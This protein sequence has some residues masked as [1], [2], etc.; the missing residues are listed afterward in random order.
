MALQIGIVGCG[1]ISK[2]HFPGFEAAGA[3]IR[4]V[5]D[6]DEAVAAPWKDRY[7]ATYTDDYTEVTS[8]PEI[9]VV[10]ITAISNVHR[11]VALSAFEHGKSV[12]CEKTLAISAEDAAEIVEA[13]RDAGVKLFTSYMK[14]F[15]PAVEDAKRLLSEGALGT[16][17]STSIRAF[18]CWGDLW[19]KAPKEGIFS[20]SHDGVSGVVR[21][22]GGGILVCGGSHILDLVCH[23]LGRPEKLL[24]SMHVPRGADF[25]VQA[26]AFLFTP[27]GIAHFEALAHPLDRIG[28]L[29]DGW[30]ERIEIVGTK[31]R[32]EVLSSSWNEVDAKGS[33]LNYY[34]NATRTETEHRYGPVSP[35]TRAIEAFCNA[36]ATGDT[37]IQSEVTGY[38]VDE[39]ISCVN[40]S[41][42][43]GKAVSPAWRLR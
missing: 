4:A 3:R 41:A 35:F 25:D 31:G 40:D 36:I 26:A 28:F 42:R 24:A 14:R 13:S 17:M 2:F 33:I 12:I 1:G 7:D 23:F 37:S 20:P 39:L 43:T 11:E 18:Q 10:D 8:D 30:D 5:C 15:I 38:D 19:D 27:R 22:Y 21:R 9:D 32:I 34:D 29:R 6:L 16:I